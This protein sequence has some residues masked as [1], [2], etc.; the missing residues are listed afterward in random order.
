MPSRDTSR[1]R[2]R[3][4]RSTPQVDLERQAQENAPTKEEPKKRTLMD[5]WQEPSLAAQPSYRDHH[6][7]PYGVLEHMQ[8]LGEPPN[9]KVKA[10]VRAEGPRKSVLGR[11]SAAAGY[12]VQETPE[13]TPGPQPPTSPQVNGTAHPPPVIDDE[14]DADY[15]PA[16]K[17]DRS[18]RSRPT[19]RRSEPTPATS[20]TSTAAAPT[21]AED[22]TVK[23]PK[24]PKKERVYDAEKLKRVVEAAQ[25]RARAVGKPDLAAAVHEIWVESLKNNHLTDLLEAILTQTASAAQTEEFQAFVKRAKQRLRDAK[26]KARKQPAGK[27]ASATQALPHRSPA[28][29]DQ[30][31]TPAAPAPALPSTEPLEVPRPKISVKQPSPPRETNGRCKSGKGPKMSAS[32]AKPGQREAS[33]ESELTDLTSDGED[34]MDIDETD[35]LATG[36]PQSPVKANGTRVND[37]AAER[38]SLAAPDRKPKRPSADVDLE[39]EERDRS[40]T[41]KKQKLGETVRRE[42]PFEESE[43]R[44]SLQATSQARQSRPKNKVVPLPLNLAPPG[45]LAAAGR[46]SRGPSTEIDSPLSELPPA[47]SRLSTPR[48]LKVPA[49]PPAKRAKT[50]NS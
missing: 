32:P 8:P 28:K 47:S 30:T 18:S 27:G 39:E 10:R 49:K 24:K 23:M 31:P 19:G 35:S 41:A 16:V 20:G 3:E 40:L 33:V 26:A 25:E 13:G 1:S 43:M 21:P 34:D 22:S 48:V 12:D 45:A 2:L 29:S 5:H 17:K 6:G 15:E 4:R 36:P 46:G 9:A 44:G 38:G 14:K 42:V 37:H 11:S 7:A 50:K